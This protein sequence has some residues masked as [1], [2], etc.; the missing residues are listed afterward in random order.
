MAACAAVPRLA[1][2][3]SDLKPFLPESDAEGDAQGDG[4]G[5]VQ[6]GAYPEEDADPADPQWDPQWDSNAADYSEED[7][8]WY[9]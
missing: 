3:Y 5:G 7:G 4:Q 8:E 2:T 6:G 1:V 9:R